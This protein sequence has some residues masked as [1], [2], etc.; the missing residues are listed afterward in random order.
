MHVKGY[1]EGFV[2]YLGNPLIVIP[3]IV[4]ETFSLHFASAVDQY[5]VKQ[6]RAVAAAAAAAE[7][8]AVPKMNSP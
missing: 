2:A 6:Q 7:A 8:V 4:T 5:L 1:L 3:V